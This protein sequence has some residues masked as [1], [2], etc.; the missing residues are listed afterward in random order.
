MLI[1]VFD[2]SIFDDHIF[3]GASV[4][5][6]DAIFDDNIFD[7][8]ISGVFVRALINNNGELRQIID[9]ELGNKKALVVS[10]GNIIEQY[11]LVGKAL[12]YDNGIIREKNSAE[13]LIL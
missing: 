11:P 5:F 8:S 6:D 7:I 3:G 12:V 10:D 9:S 2:A 4:L 13:T 1:N